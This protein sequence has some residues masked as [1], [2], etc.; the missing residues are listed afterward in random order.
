MCKQR[1][2]TGNED[3]T[4]SAQFT[5]YNVL[6]TLTK[7]FAPFLPYVTEKVFQGLF[8]GKEF[9]DSEKF[10][11]IH[12]SPWP[13][14]NQNFV[15]EFAE[16]VGASLVEI[17]TA[18]RRHKSENK[19]SLG[20]NVEQLLIRTNNAKLATYLRNAKDDLISI[21]RAEEI[22][23]NNELPQGSIHILESG[24]INAYLVL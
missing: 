4:R 20:S 7:L 9:S 5:L 2:Y 14:V 21:T 22:S 17:A 16:Q 1:L 8:V 3:Q 10:N 13:E 23:I 15:D 11:S 18:V 19:M 6:L 24:K 12:L